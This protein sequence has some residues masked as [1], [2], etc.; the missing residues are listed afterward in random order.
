MKIWT[1]R[2]ASKL[3]AKSNVVPVAISRGLPRYSTGYELKHRVWMLAPTAKTF[4]LESEAAY[5]ESYRSQLDRH[6]PEKIYRVLKEIS[7]QENGAELVLLCFEDVK[8]DW[9][10]R[11]M[12]ARWWKDKTGTDITELG[13]PNIALDKDLGQMRLV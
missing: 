12:F 5:E 2:F 1:S 6:G 13:D 7:D 8:K 10:H 11:T 4:A 9:C 3:I